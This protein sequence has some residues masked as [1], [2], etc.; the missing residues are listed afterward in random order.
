M[1]NITIHIYIYMC[2]YIY[3]LCIYIYRY[4]YIYTIHGSY[5]IY[6]MTWPQ[7]W[8]WHW[9]L[10]PAEPS[11]RVAASIVQC[12]ASRRRNK[13]TTQFFNKNMEQTPKKEWSLESTGNKKICLQ[14]IS[15]FF[16]LLF[17]VSQLPSISPSIA[18]VHLPLSLRAKSR[19][20][21][22]SLRAGG[23]IIWLVVEPPDKYEM[24]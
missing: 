8:P 10:V 18:A 24:G 21:P 14:W 5:G 13:G 6:N 16:S 23:I 7:I 3:I 22:R 20:T 1:V 15:Y 9:Q 2:I 19:C 11:S 17:H 12:P 4:I